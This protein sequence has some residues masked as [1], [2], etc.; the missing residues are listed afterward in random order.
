[1]AGAG[2]PVH[3][4]LQRFVGE[5]FDVRPL[6]PGP[7]RPALDGRHTGVRVIYPHD[8]G[9]N[10]AGLAGHPVKSLKRVL[11]REYS[12]K[13]SQLVRRGHRAHTAHRAGR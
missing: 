8:H 5:R 6:E 4:G 3:P 2:G 9:A 11:A 12:Q 1:M 7:A 10:D 13:L